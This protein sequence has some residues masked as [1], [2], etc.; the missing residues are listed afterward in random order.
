VITGKNDLHTHVVLTFLF[1]HPDTVR[2]RMIPGG[3]VGG[4]P[5]RS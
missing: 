4:I 1:T 2:Y 3:V 5:M